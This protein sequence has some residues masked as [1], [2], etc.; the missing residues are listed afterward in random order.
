M[1]DHLDLGVMDH[2]GA[3]DKSRVFYQFRASLFLTFRF[4]V[5]NLVTGHWVPYAPVVSSCERGST[6]ILSYYFFLS[7]I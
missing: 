3:A 1:E 6:S 2:S 5:S 7:N 4:V